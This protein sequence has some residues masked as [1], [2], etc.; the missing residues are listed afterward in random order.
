MV[1]GRGASAR[2][3]AL[4]IVTTAIFTVKEIL[5]GAI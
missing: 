5:E 1:A 3:P 2:M 4:T